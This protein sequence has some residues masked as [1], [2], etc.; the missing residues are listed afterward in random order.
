MASGPCS[1]VLIAPVGSNTKGARTRVAPKACLL[2][3]GVSPFTFVMFV[4]AGSAAGALTYAGWRTQTLRRKWWL[5]LTRSLKGAVCIRTCV[6]VRARVVV[7]APPPSLRMRAEPC[8][9]PPEA[10]IQNL[11]TGD[12][13]SPRPP[14]PSLALLLCF[15][16]SSFPLLSPLLSLLFVALEGGGGKGK[17]GTRQR[18]ARA[19]VGG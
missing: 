2:P 3:H 4:R 6:R 9:G 19:G 17:R 5:W 10:A 16:N 12:Q 15:L 7:H 18:A 1:G 8:K 11:A 14:P 13:A